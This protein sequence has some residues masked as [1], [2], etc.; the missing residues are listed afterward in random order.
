MSLRFAKKFGA[1]SDHTAVEMKSTAFSV[2]KS[3]ALLEK[4]TN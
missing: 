2:L 1:Y 4:H 3:I